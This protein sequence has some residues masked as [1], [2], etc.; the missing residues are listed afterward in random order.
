MT[1]TR[2]PK[3]QWGQRVRAGVDL[4]NDGSHP[5]HPADA[6]LVAAGAS[7]EIVQTG[8]HVESNTPVYVV[9]FTGVAHVVGC[10]EEEIAPE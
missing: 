6:L 5:E 9:E 3:Y 1:D 8:M 4:Y 10:L 2:E 7:G